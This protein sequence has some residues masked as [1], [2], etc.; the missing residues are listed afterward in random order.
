M[1][2]SRGQSGP[3]KRRMWI[4]AKTKTAAANN[5]GNKP[6]VVSCVVRQSNMVR[7]AL[8]IGESVLRYQ[9]ADATFDMRIFYWKRGRSQHLTRIKWATANDSASLG[10]EVWK[11]F[12]SGVY[13]APPL[14]WRAYADHRQT[15]QSQRP[16][17]RRAPCLRVRS[18]RDYPGHGVGAFL[19]CG[20][21]A[22]TLFAHS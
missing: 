9:T 15:A 6:V 18:L 20:I 3:R 17:S 2:A 4:V 11:S 13:S 21:V 10:V 16:S 1:R 5:A 8:A 22:D 7:C 19:A 12:K 14:D